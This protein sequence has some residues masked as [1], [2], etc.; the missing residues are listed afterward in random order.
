MVNFRSFFVA[1]VRD[2]LT[3]EKLFAFKSKEH[4]RNAKRVF[5]TKYLVTFLFSW[6]YIVRV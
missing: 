3:V 4:D 5:F 2:K 1:L 6:T